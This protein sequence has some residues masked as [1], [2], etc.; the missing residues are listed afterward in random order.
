[1]ITPEQRSEFL[2]LVDRFFGIRVSDYSAQRLDHAINRVLPTTTCATPAELLLTL[3][4]GQQARWLNDVVEYL[5]VGETY[6]FRDP[7]QISAVRDTVLPDL[8]DRRSP[9]RRL[10]MW[11]AGCST[12]EELYTLAMLVLDQG[13]MRDPAWDVLLFGTDV[14]RESLRFARE[15]RYSTRSFRAT[16]DQTRERYFEAIDQAWRPIE[17]IRRM[18]HFA[19]TNLGADQPIPPAVELDLIMCRNVTIYFADAATQRLYATLVGAL[20]LGGWLLL[21]PSDALPADR[22]E[23]ERVNAHNAVL[24]RRV[25]P[26]KR[27]KRPP[28]PRVVLQP[29]AIPTRVPRPDNARTELNA[30]L[31]ALEAGSAVW[32]LEE[33]RR[34]TFRDP[35]SVLGQ[36][37]L[38][39]AYLGVGDFSHARAAL[40]QTRRLLMP[41]AG[42]AFVT[43]A[44]SLH[45][46]T[47]RQTIEIKLVAIA[48]RQDI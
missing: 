18:T 43:G 35:G 40:L 12:G 34:A 13:I 32:A 3:G 16:P 23:L 37:A 15:G 27:P 21:G 1:M 33:L 45:V 25:A 31:L 26:V 48:G 39:S 20:A 19:W 17:P 47:L 44:D 5:T 22:S 36:F 10:R 42:D 7:S 9:E 11:S 46:E 14:N 29:E 38:A 30:G 24:W 4:T 6:F 2:G 41:L 28:K 8:I